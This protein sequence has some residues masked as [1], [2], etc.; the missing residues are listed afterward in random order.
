MNS[1]VE[2]WK[3]GIAKSSKLNKLE[4]IHKA[5]PTFLAHVQTSTDQLQL[6]SWEQMMNGELYV[7]VKVLR[8]VVVASF[9]S[10]IGRRVVHVQHLCLRIVK[11]TSQISI[12]L[13]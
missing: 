5:P 7:M 2:R 4:T 12:P 1:L 11:Y 10:V 3:R 8:M 13:L 9:L 6:I